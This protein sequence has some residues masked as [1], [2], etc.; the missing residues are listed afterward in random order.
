MARGQSDLYSDFA[1]FIPARVIVSAIGLPD[2]D[3]DR[4]VDWAIVMT[5][6]AETAERRASATEAMSQYVRPLCHARRREPARDLISILVEATL[7]DEEVEEGGGLERHPLT[8][9]EIDA[10]A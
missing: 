6:M 8:D 2:S 5:S 1:A 7:T 9:S 4:F 3:L 10:L